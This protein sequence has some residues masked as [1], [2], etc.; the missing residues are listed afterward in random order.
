[1]KNLKTIKGFTLIELMIV[2]AIIGILAAIA[3][4]NYMKYQA[5]A[6]QSEAKSNLN[7][8]FSV[9]MSYFAEHNTFTTEFTE[10]KWIPV[11]PYRYAYCMGGTVMGLNLPLSDAEHNDPPGAGLYAFTA[12]AWGNV[13]SDPAIDTW[14]IGGSIP[15]ANKYDDVVEDA[16]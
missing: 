13:D 2:V 12:V 5:K 9:E 16:R 8:V 7:G 14:E 3:I 10:L 4:P 6:K 15:L 11:G 1:M